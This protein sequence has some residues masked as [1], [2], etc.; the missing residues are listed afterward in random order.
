MNACPECGAELNARFEGSSYVL[1]CRTCE[2]GVA[3]TWTEPIYEDETIYSF[4]L[5]ADKDPS[6][7]A[8]SEVS[9]IASCNYIASKQLLSN[10][11]EPL[12]HCPAP[13]M[14]QYADRLDAAKVDYVI[15]PPFPY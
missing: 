11:T 3:T 13:E 1:V 15:T 6:K 14:K 2:W 12:V 8:L 7:E 5:Q 9:K 4:L 10:P